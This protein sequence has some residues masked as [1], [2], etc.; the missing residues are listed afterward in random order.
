MVEQTP[1]EECFEY[2]FQLVKAENQYSKH[3]STSDVE[4][5]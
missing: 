1:V 4:Q 3:S 2:D 5:I